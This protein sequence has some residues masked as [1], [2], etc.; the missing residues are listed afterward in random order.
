MQTFTQRIVAELDGPLTRGKPEST[1]GNFVADAMMQ[2]MKKT[3]GVQPDFVLQILV[4]CAP[5]CQRA[6]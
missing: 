3:T 1:L 2:H 6:H 5:T 4:A